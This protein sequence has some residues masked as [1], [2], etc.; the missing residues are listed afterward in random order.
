MNRVVHFEIQATKPERAIKFYTE[1]FGWHIYKW[2]S[3]E[4]DYWAV[5]TA[6]KDSK[7]PG[8]NGG[9]LVRPADVPPLECGTNAFVCTI[10][11]ENF[12]L[13]AKKSCK[14]GAR[15]QCQNLHCRKWHGLDIF[16]ILRITLSGYIKKTKTQ[17]ERVME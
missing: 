15:L 9:L 6:P 13:I 16:W 5:E 7:D 2:E 8:I 4:T 10:D 17:N 3:M 11:V 12:D 1:V 14:L